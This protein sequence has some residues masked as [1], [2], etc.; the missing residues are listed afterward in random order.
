METSDLRR[1]L[2]SAICTAVMGSDSR[3]KLWLRDEL[4]AIPFESRTD[5]AL[6]GMARKVLPAARVDKYVADKSAVRYDVPD[7]VLCPECNDTKLIELNPGRFAT[8]RNCCP[9]PETAT[10]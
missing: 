6:I 2:C 1:S 8:C 3:W 10:A 4:A 7:L 5:T 9:L